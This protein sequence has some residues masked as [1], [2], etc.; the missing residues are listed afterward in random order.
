MSIGVGNGNDVNLAKLFAAIEAAER[1]AEKAL[2]RGVPALRRLFK[3]A[4]GDT[5]QAG[6]AARFLAG[7]YNGPRFRFDL[8]E[9]RGVDDAIFT[10]MMLVLT[11]DARACRQEVHEYF[12]DGQQAFEQMI[13]DWRIER[14]RSGDHRGH[15]AGR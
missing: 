5:G 6:V 10:D 3:L 4:Q 2:E 12:N 14:R 11:M 7:L 1:F 13:A 8:T 15:D 9:L